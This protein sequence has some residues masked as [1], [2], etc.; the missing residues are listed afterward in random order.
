MWLLRLLAVLTALTVAGGV[1]A[2]LFTRDARYLQF[3]WSLFR[4]SLIVALLVFALMILER[5]AVIPV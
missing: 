4:Y 3:A 2:F 1:L 5:V